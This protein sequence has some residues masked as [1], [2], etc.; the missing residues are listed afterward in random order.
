M[1]QFRSKKRKDGSRFSYPITEPLK[2]VR[3]EPFMKV[4]EAQKGRKESDDVPKRFHKEVL[5]YKVYFVDGDLIKERYR[6]DFFY[7]GHGYA[8][9]FIPLDEIWMIDRG[10]AMDEA[11]IFHEVVEAEIMEKGLPYKAKGSGAHSLAEQLEKKLKATGRWKDRYKIMRQVKYGNEAKVRR[12]L[13][14][15]LTKET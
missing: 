7:A 10:E 2:R 4:Y 6:L 12:L 1:P 14:A 11:S 13:E 5:G 15:K 8:L 9:K 3:R